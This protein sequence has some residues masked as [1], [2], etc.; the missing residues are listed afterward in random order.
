MAQRFF[1]TPR[2]FD[3]ARSPQAPRRAEVPICL[4]A[5]RGLELGKARPLVGL[6]FIV[7]GTFLALA[8][9]SST[10]E[11]AFAFVSPQS[12]V[13]PADD[14]TLSSLAQSAESV[15]REGRASSAWRVRLGT[16]LIVLGLILVVGGV[17]WIMDRAATTAPGPPDGPGE[18]LQ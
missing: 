16:G 6:A 4:E 7:L 2:L 12:P 18:R 13:V 3:P 1:G 17:L 14:E 11:R 15:S 8:F 5:P 9:L 10:G